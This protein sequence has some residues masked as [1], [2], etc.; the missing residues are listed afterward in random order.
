MLDVKRV[1]HYDIDTMH[2]FFG[3][4]IENFEKPAELYEHGFYVELAEEK[5][6]FFALC[7]VE[8]NSVW[9]KSLYIQQDMKP[10]FLLTLLEIIQAYAKEDNIDN[11]YVFCK[12]H[13]I[14]RLLEAHQFQQLEE[15]G[16]SELVENKP[17]VDGTW[18]CYTV[19][20]I[21]G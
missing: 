10:N 15:V 1:N 7:P 20:G 5:K 3:E 17:S 18:W 13:T 4:R 9:L 2:Q 8:D 14:E 21:K 16:V 12:Q 19:K 6:G 11:I